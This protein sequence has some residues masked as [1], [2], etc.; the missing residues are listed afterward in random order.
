MVLFRLLHSNTAHD[1]SRADAIDPSDLK[2]LLRKRNPSVES[3]VKCDHQVS[4]EPKMSNVHHSEM[5]SRGSRNKAATPSRGSRSKATSAAT[6]VS[7]GSRPRNSSAVQP[8]LNRSSPPLRIESIPNPNHEPAITS[9][10]IQEVLSHISS[11]SSR[12][13]GSLGTVEDDTDDNSVQSRTG[14]GS[15]SKMVDRASSPVGF[16]LPALDQDSR[17]SVSV[18]SSANSKKQIVVKIPDGIE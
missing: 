17:G 11:P 6:R 18:S 13:E 1:V 15:H 8:P 10:Y 9:Q 4:Q 12:I 7:V 5:S 3:I 14:D 16:R 2:T